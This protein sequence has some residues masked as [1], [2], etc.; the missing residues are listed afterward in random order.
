MDNLLHDDELDSD[1]VRSAQAGD[2]DALD[3]LV[4]RHQT[5][6]F[7][8]A[9]R[10]LWNRAD[11]EDATQE[12]FVKAITHLGG[13]EQRSGFR[14]WLYRIAGNHLLD[15]CRSAKTF[16]G[17]AQ[18]LSATPD[19]DL[20]DPNST[21]LETALLIEEAKIACTAGILLCLA[22]R[23]RL[24]FIL[25]E[26]LGVTD[27]VGSV[28]LETTPGNFRQILS[29]S[30]R[31]LYGFL[32]QQCGL[33][34]ESNPC[35][36]AKKARGFIDKGIVN[37]DRPQFVIDRITEVRRVAPDRFHELQELER[38]HAEVF[39]DQPLLAAPD[40]AVLVRDLLQ[41]SGVR[42]SMGIDQ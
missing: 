2:R 15:R 18:S 30:R 4:R 12:I 26:I 20:P 13:F 8:I 27:D 42:R 6:I 35:R 23:Q 19:A 1:L 29:R 9:Q 17:M 40:Q 32:N 31:D 16:A 7:H 24:A 33:V 36:C 3:S 22:P 5:W 14:T 21:R 25:G 28:V 38:L 11:A 37:P 34:N 41:Q 10:M 39:R